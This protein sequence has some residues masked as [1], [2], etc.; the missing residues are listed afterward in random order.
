MARESVLCNYHWAEAEIIPAHQWTAYLC[1]LYREARER[2][3]RSLVVRFNEIR[4]LLHFGAPK[5]VT[6]ALALLDETLSLPPNHWQID[7]MEDVF[8]WDFFPQFFNYRGYFD[9]VTQHLTQGVP[10]EADL[11]RLI[12]ASLYAYRGFYPTYHGFYSQALDDF[13]AAAALDPDFPFFQLWYADQ[14]LRRGLDEDRR[15]ASGILHELASGSLV[16]REAL[17]WLV[18]IGEGS[19]ELARRVSRV[20]EVLR[21]HE[22]SMAVPKLQPDL[23]AGEAERDKVWAEWETWSA[24]REHLYNL[25]QG[26][27]SSKFWKL[28]QAWIEIKRLLS[29][30]SRTAANHTNSTKKRRKR[31]Y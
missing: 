20:Q 29:R 14:L 28:R 25:I 8:P 1:E 4:V 31:T 18:K 22:F 21:I 12:L 23:R 15:A 7:V 26:M 17:E 16:F 5:L 13:G 24:E 30:R 3:P 6:E 27:Q 9:R 2:F 10:V 11:C 19:E